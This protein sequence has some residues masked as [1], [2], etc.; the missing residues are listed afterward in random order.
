M[1]RKILLLFV[2]SIVIV[3]FATA[4]WLSRVN[5][6]Q[7]KGEMSLQG[8]DEPVRVVRDSLGIPY[9]YANSRDDA[10]LTQGF[11]IAQDRLF[12]LEVL[13][14]LSQGRFAEI[15]GAGG[16]RSDI[17]IRVVGVP[18]VGK[19][20][21]ANLSPESRVVMALYA[22][23]INAY[24]ENYDAEFQL[25]LQVLDIEPQPWTVEDLITVNTFSN[26]SSSG[27]IEEELIAQA[28][29]DKVGSERADEIS[30]VSINPDD[31]DYVM[32]EPASAS[33]NL[34]LD[35]SNLFAGAIAGQVELGSNHWAISGQRTMSGSAMLANNPHMDSRVLPGLWYPMA[36]IT[37]ENRV[38][39]AAALGAPGFAVART[40]YIAFGIT[41]S[42][43]DAADLYVETIDPENPDNY[44]EGDQSIPFDVVDETFLVRNRR[45]GD[46]YAEAARVR[47]TKRGP[48]ISDH[49]LTLDDGRVIT[50]RWAVAEHPSREYG[51]AALM[52]AKNLTEAEA[53][54]AD[55]DSP[56][57]FTVVTATGDIGHFTAGRIPNRKR[58]DGS[59]PLEV[60]NS[61]DNW[62]GVIPAEAMPKT[63]NPARGWVGN[64]NH[65]TLP[66]DYPYE[67]SSYFAHSWRYERMRELL[68]VSSQTT[69]L[70]QWGHMFDVKNMMAER[71]TPYMIRALATHR[72]TGWIAAHLR[73]WDFNDDADAI[74]PLLFQA[75]Y[76]SF[77]TMTFKDDLGE[78][79]ATKMLDSQ[80]YWQERMLLMLVDNESLWFDDRN[81]FS[82][83]SRDDLF[84]LAA[85]A[86]M[87]ELESRTGTAPGKL[88]WGDVHTVTFSSPL[89]PG[90]SVAGIF[91]GG[92]FAKE[93]SGET[94]NRA[95]FYLSKAYDSVFIDSMRFVADMGDPD[96]VMGVVSGGVSGRLFDDHLNDQIELWRTGEPVYWWYSD[97]A[98]EQNTK[99]ELLLM[100]E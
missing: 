13:R 89:I 64:A 80:Y 75:I 86:A 66:A 81:T 18:R 8:L 87:T 23:G 84:Y 65:R 24:I 39:G 41:N 31:G 3:L 14:Y 57:N 16:I 60:T 68:D 73:Q 22:A 62:K 98:I 59:R 99:S 88:T 74:A 96:K 48:V 26:W 47:F 95:K 76:R 20:L 29:I 67:Y 53:A 100:P 52:V 82:V 36:I 1:I 38:V 17:Q 6:Y 9:I 5:D 79:L 42:Y 70:E 90:K 55:I 71:V 63:I 72:D 33:L 46:F 54:V 58:G 44:L 69:A 4:L 40:N 43:G 51:L 49:G 19:Q 27:N 12:Q 83:E 37:P 32:A 91:G 85:K 7:T 10:I 2:Y 97:R 50:L 92:T 77:V 11:L 78:D 94:I 25:G 56:Y 45:S 61:E 34:D 30:I 93:G 21:A 28:I 35:L 15:I